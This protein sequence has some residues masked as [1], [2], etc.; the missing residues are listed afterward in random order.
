MNLESDAW[1]PRRAETVLREVLGKIGID[2]GDFRLL[3]L[4][5]NMSFAVDSAALVVRLSRPYAT[6]AAIENEIGC[7]RYLEEQ[8][9]PAG[10]LFGEVRQPLES[11]L[12]WVT[13]WRQQ[14]GRE[15][16]DEDQSHLG[17]L[18]GLLHRLPP[19]SSMRSW[20]PLSKV[21]ERMRQISL[22]GRV[23]EGDIRF[24]W[25][26][27]SRLESDAT[28]LSRACV[29]TMCHGDAHTGNLLIDDDSE[30]A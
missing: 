3:R 25:G 22:Q 27:K 29:N 21:D 12:G 9:Y 24:L 26:L 23:P 18:L 28:A 7:A 19:S 8:G 11:R 5:E 10:R 17:H 15:G 14:A 1:T 30:T 6:E 13:L 16:K 20:A 2:A 4:G